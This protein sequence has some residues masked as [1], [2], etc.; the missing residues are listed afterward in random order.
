M[1]AMLVYGQLHAQTWSG[2]LAPSRAT[3]WSNAGIPGGVPS[4]S[5][6]QCGP[7]IVAYGASASPG[8]PA[9]I[10]NAI[11]GTGSGYT[12]CAT[13]YVIMLGSGDF[14]LNA[15]INLRSNVVLR[16]AGAN[17]TRVHFVNGGSYSCNGITSVSCVVGSN[18][19]GG[20]C[21]V[22]QWPCPPGQWVQS[23]TTA[24]W[25]GGYSQGSSTITLDSV[26]GIVP[27]L[28]PIVLDQCDVGFTGSPGVEN[29]TAVAGVITAANVYPSGGGSGYAVNDTGTINPS[30]NFGR[31][32][33]SGTATYRV[34]SVGTGGAVTGFTITNGGGGYT[35]TSTG[36]FGSATGTTKTSGSGSGFQVQITGV[37]GWDNGSLFPCAVTMICTRQSDSGTAR[38]ARSQQEVV[39]ATSI[40]GTGPYTVTLSRPIM[41]PNWASSQGPQAWW[42]SS[43]ITNAGI[44]NLLFD[45]STISGGASAATIQT[46]YHVWVKG[47]ASNTA[48]FFHIYS[49]VDSNFVVR[50]SYF[51]MTTNQGTT[52]YG[53]GSGGAV[54]NALYENN[55]IQGVVDP[56]VPNGTC[57]GCVFAYNFSINDANWSTNTMF[58]SSPMHSAATDY[59]LEEGN[60][61]AGAN[62]DNTHGPHFMNTFYRNYFNGYERNEG[63]LP[64][65]ITMPIIVGAFSRYNNIVANV[66]GTPGYHTG[67]QCVPSSATQ[68]YCSLYG[69]PGYRHI[70]DVGFSGDS[71]I[72]FNNSPNSPNDPL[73]A[74]SLLRW[75][76]W[77]NVTNAARWCGTST[78]TAWSSTCGGASEVP[79]SDSK[80]PNSIPTL[81]DTGSG[82]GGLPASFYYSSKPSWW[83]SGKAWPAIG[84]DVTTGNIGQ[85]S[86]GTYG[87]S[88]ALSGSSCTGGSFTSAATTNGSHAVSIPAMDCYFNIMSGPPDGSGS[89][90]AFNA[91][92]CYT[93]SGS[94]GSGSGSGTGSSPV[95]PATVSS[96]VH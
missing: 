56:I 8:T 21:N 59:I 48:N 43:T 46:A 14:Y 90:L 84:P 92:T 41:H 5:W 79:V 3:S 93:N 72:D 16:G 15:S 49:F 39:V 64:T 63:V 18:T 67:Y 4:G 71:Q 6:T 58:A 61:G 60:I 20:Y 23:G 45:M 40:S 27:N 77:D 12:G 76:N 42:G 17:S 26:A 30:T 57:T 75:G 85:C 1:G 95:P 62:M 51:Y 11:A 24:N 55:V 73:T 10:N 81:G 2:I 7:T 82:Q 33:G 44:E 87:F 74:S 25:T 88:K 13:P 22:S 50:D 68:Q 65:Q 69:S 34:T 83:P 47:I 91:S 35:Y 52:S 70:F 66:L 29:C 80:F 38:N 37:T 32:Y 89:M 53:I 94:T 86:G 96:T 28:T 31:G 9:T 36:Y 54:G 19:Y 78:N